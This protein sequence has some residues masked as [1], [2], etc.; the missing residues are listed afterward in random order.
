MAK[1]R[2]TSPNGETYEVT[3]PD[4]A[5]ESDVLAYAQKQFA[6]KQPAIDPTEGM[7]TTDKVLAGVGK[8][9]V[10]T[11]RGVGQLLRKAL[12]ERASNAIGLPTQQDI[13]QAKKLDEPLMKTKAGLGGNILGSGALSIPTAAIPGANGVTANVLIGSLLAG[14]QPV[15]TGESRTE[16][17]AWGGGGGGV[18]AMFANTVGRL[19][20][21]VQSA[22]PDNLNPLAVRAEQEFGIPL[23]A[24]QRTGS[25]PLRIVDAVLDNLPF[26]ATRQAAEKRAQR[27]AYNRAILRQIGEN[28]DQATPDVLNAARTRIGRQFEDISARNTVNLGDD[29]LE[30]LA[31]VD[32]ARTPFSSPQIN[33]VVENALDLAAQGRISGA[34]YQR[35]RTSLTNAAKSSWGSDPERGQAL[36]AV[37]QALDRA[38]DGS[39][40]EADQA[41]WRTARQQWGNLKAIED[42]AKPVSADAVSGNISP[43]KLASAIMKNNRH[44]MI[45][46]QGDQV[47][48]DLARIG[49]AFIREQVPDSGTAQRAMYQA[50][51]TGSPATA[52]LMMSNPAMLGTALSTLVLPNVA[53]RVLHSN[54][55]RTY[56]SR[57]MI[58]NNPTTAQIARALRQGSAGAGSAFL[59]NRPE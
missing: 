18:G 22:L 50:L 40:S 11:G 30:T 44:G 32:A 48:P 6:T 57:G 35:V 8:T 5:S 2:V 36:R 20:R 15:A 24:A 42:A 59:A 21:P 4:D 53:Q 17:M 9:F 3:A 52:G 37:R 29:F 56:F 34:E 19:I 41:A 49:Q 16:N 1:Y 54:A 31:R 33:G 13:D 10:D 26:S 55:G 45:Y 58:P 47:M 12:P 28:A 23:N 46:G 25:R 14:L 43:A 38:A 51:L 39:I 7:T 27:E